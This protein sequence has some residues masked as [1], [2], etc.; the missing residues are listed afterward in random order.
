M[1]YFVISRR[2]FLRS[3]TH[4]SFFNNSFLTEV[5]EGEISEYECANV[6]TDLKQNK[7]PGLDG[8][9]AEFYQCFREEFIP[10]LVTLYNFSF[11]K[12]MLPFSQT[13]SVIALIHKKGEKHDIKNYRPISITNIDY[14]ILAT[15]DAMYHE[16]N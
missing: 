4:V 11:D 10:F 12:G 2:N 1:H 6:I 3:C 15:Y 5:C 14:K 7:S 13:H 16:S 8:L 9:T